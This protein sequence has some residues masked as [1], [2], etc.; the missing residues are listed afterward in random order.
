M[1]EAW[2]WLGIIALMLVTRSLAADTAPGTA[3]RASDSDT[4][5]PARTPWFITLNHTTLQRNIA[6]LSPQTGDTDITT[7]LR[8]PLLEAAEDIVQVPL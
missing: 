5:T 6:S 3:Q 4:Q 2:A 8:L 1:F 7:L